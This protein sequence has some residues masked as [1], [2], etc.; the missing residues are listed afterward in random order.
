MQKYLDVLIVLLVLLICYLIYSIIAKIQRNSKFGED[1]TS[2][3]DT[4]NL[5]KIPEGKTA[6]FYAAWCGHCRA[7]MDDFKKA[8]QGSKGIVIMIPESEENKKIFQEYNID[9]FPTIMN[10]KGEKYRGGRTAEEII[11]FAN[12]K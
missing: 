2:V 9:S 4:N 12:G 3:E 10:S 6:I 8:V 5:E 7:S 11:D 1:T